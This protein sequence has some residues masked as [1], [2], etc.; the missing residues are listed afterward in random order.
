[1]SNSVR[2]HRWQPK[3]LKSSVSE[4]DTDTSCIICSSQVL[5]EMVGYGGKGLNIAHNPGGP[6]KAVRGPLVSELQVPKVVFL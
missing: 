5:G 2:P 4:P 3:A 1:M 6:L